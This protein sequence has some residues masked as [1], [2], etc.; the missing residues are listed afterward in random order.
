MRSFTAHN[1]A[2]KKDP[3]LDGKLVKK[4]PPTVSDSFDAFFV[5]VWYCVEYLWE[6]EMKS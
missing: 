2:D 3:R 6:K 4:I 5:F 1:N